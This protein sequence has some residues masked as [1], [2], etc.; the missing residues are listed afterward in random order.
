M[1]RTLNRLLS[2]VV[3][4]SLAFPASTMDGV[5]SA[6]AQANPLT[7]SQGGVLYRTRIQARYPSAWK[8]LDQT[9]IVVLEKGVDSALILVT[10]S[11]LKI[12]AQYQYWPQATVELSD[13]VQSNSAQRPD[14]KA[15]L[16]PILDRA[17]QLRSMSA[18]G[19]SSESELNQLING[20]SP[21]DRQRLSLLSASDTDNDGLT[22]TEEA[23]WC[24]DPNNPDSDGDTVSDGLEVTHLLAGNRTN[25]KPF[26][27]WPSSHPGCSDDDFDSLPDAAETHVTGTNSNRESTDL[28]KYD[29][30]QEF[31][32]I[33]YCPG[34]P[35]S[36]GYGALPRTED[37][38]LGSNMPS[39]VRAPGNSPWIAAFPDPTVAINDGT[40]NVQSV[41]IITTDHTIGQGES[42][43]Y[44]TATTVGTSTSN[45]DITSWND[46]QEVK[47]ENSTSHTPTLNPTFNMRSQSPQDALSWIQVGG[48]TLSVIGAAGAVVCTLS[49]VCGVVFGTIGVV[50]AVVALGATV[51]EKRE[52]LG[53][54]DSQHPSMDSINKPELCSVAGPGNKTCIP[55]AVYDQQLQN[56]I[57]LISKFD[58]RQDKLPTEGGTEFTLNPDGTGS[59]QHADSGNVP[60]IPE[61]IA[62]R[63]PVTHAK[64]FGGSKGTITTKYTETTTTSIQ[65][66]SSSESWSNATATDTAHAADLRFTYTIRNDGRDILREVDGLLFN[67][68]LGGKPDPIYTYNVVAQ[69]GIIRNIQ[70]GQELTLASNPVPLTLQQMAEIDK[71]SSILITVESLSYGGDQLFFQDAANGG[72][73]VAIDDGFADGDN[74]LDL[75]VL[76][77]YGSPCGSDPNETVQTILQR[78]F[79][80][81]EDPEGTLLSIST[82]EVSGN[83][84]TWIQHALTYTSWWNVYVG[85][86]MAYTGSLATTLP[87]A[88]GALVLR[89]LDDSDRD[90]YNDHTEDLLGTDKNDPGSHPAPELIAGRVSERAGDSVK[91]TVAFLNAGLYDAAGVEVVAFAPDDTI[92]IADNSIG[93]S[94][95]IGAGKRVVLGGRVFPPEL[96]SGW[97]GTANPASY[98]LY[99]GSLEKTYTLT[100][101]S[102]GAIGSGNLLFNWTDGTNNG[103]LQF[104]ST[105]LS[106][107]PVAVGS[108]GLTVSFNSGSIT[109]GDSFTIRVRPAGDTIT[110]TINREPYTEPVLVVSYNDPQGKHRLISPIQLNRLDED[111]TQ[112][113]GKMIPDLGLTITTQAAP[114]QAGGSTVYYVVN[115]PSDQT[116]QDAHLFV[117]YINPDG[118]PVAEQVIMQTLPPGPSVI[119]VEALAAANAGSSPGAPQA[120]TSN[121][122][123]IWTDSQGNKLDTSIRKAQDFQIDPLPKAAATTSGW[124]LGSVYQGAS[125]YR[126]FAYANVGQGFLPV[127]GEASGFQ[128]NLV[129]DRQ[130]KL[131]PLQAGTLGLLVDTSTPGPIS[132][133]LIL[134]T[135]DIQTPVIHIPVSGL[136]LATPNLS[137]SDGDVIFNR[138]NPTAGQTVTVTAD[139]HNPGPDAVA[140]VVVRFYQ[141]DPL[142]AGIQI[143]ADQ[144]I[145]VPAGGITSPTASFAY[146]PG[147]NLIHVTVD[148]GNAIAETDEND[149][150]ARGFL[151]IGASMPVNGI[152]A[153]GQV[154]KITDPAQLTNP[155]VQVTGGASLIF[156]GVT[157]TLTSL[158]VDDNANVIFDGATI[159]SGRLGHISLEPSNFLIFR[160]GSTL[161]I[162]DQNI[163]KAQRLVVSDSSIK[164]KGIDGTYGGGTGQISSIDIFAENILLNHA[165]ISSIGGNGGGGANS[166]DPVSAGGMGGSSTLSF[167]VNSKAILTDSTIEVVGGDGGE[168]GRGHDTGGMYGGPGSTG[169][170]EINSSDLFLLRSTIYAEGGNGGNGGGSDYRGGRD[171]NSGS[172]AILNISVVGIEAIQSFIKSVGGKGGQGGL[173]G[174][175]DFVSGS[176]GSGGATELTILASEIK[177]I[178]SNLENTGG[179]GGDGAG[180]GNNCEYSGNGGSG[181][182][183]L[184]SIEAN[185]MDWSPFNVTCYAGDGGITPNAYNVPGNGGS[186]GAASV[187]LTGGRVIAN[188]INLSI[189]GGIGKNGGN[190]AHSAYSSD[191]KQGGNGGSG[192]ST[193]LTIDVAAIVGETTSIALLSGNGGNGGDG[194]DNY[195]SHYAGNGGNG[196]NLTKNGQ[197]D[198]MWETQ[199]VTWNLMVGQGGAPGPNGIVPAKPGVKGTETRTLSDGYESASLPRHQI[200]AA[201]LSPGFANLHSVSSLSSNWDG[202]TS[203]TLIGPNFPVQ[204]PATQ[205]YHTLN[206]TYTFTDGTSAES[207]HR[208]YVYNA[209]TDFDSDGLL[210]T[211]E[212]NR[213]GTN[214]VV[215]DTDGDGLSDGA[216]IDAHIDPLNPDS[217][218]NGILDGLDPAVLNRPDLVPL[219]GSL[220]FSNDTPADGTTVTLSVQITNPGDRDADGIVVG[221]YDGDPYQDGVYI[222]GA[223]ISALAKNT[224]APATCDW[225]TAGLSGSHTLFAMADPPNR[226]AEKN[227]N[228]NLIS[229]PL[230]VLTK[231]DLQIQAL[232]PAVNEIQAGQPLQFDAHLLNTGQTS[233]SNVKVNLYL[234]TD[235]TGVPIA[236]ATTSLPAGGETHVTLPWSAVGSGLISFTAL[237]DANQTVPEIDETNNAATSQVFVGWGSPVYV[238]AGSANDLP[239]SGSSGYG[240]LTPGTTVT[241]CGSQP[242]QTYRQRNSG[243]QLQYRY[244]N[245]LASHFYHLDLSFYLCSGTRNLRILVDGVEVANPVTASSTSTNV[246]LLLD[247]SL[248]TDHSIVVTIERV[249][250]LGGPV[251]SEM[252]LTDIR[253]CYLDSGA[254]GEAAYAGAAD[255]CGWQSGTPDLSWGSLPY[256]SVRYNDLASVRYRFDRLTGNQDYRLNLTFFDGDSSSRVESVVIDGTPVLT[257]IVPT[258]TPQKLMVDIPPG[259]YAADGSILVDITEPYQ[260]I[261]SE[262]GLEEKTAGPGGSGLG[263]VPMAANDSYQGFSG[264]PLVVSAPG[265]LGN[266]SDPGGRT[267]TASLVDD[268]T[269]GSLSLSSSG[270]FTYTSAP[271][272]L[273]N[274]TFTYRVFNGIDYST[275]ATVT[276]TI[277][278]RVFLPNIQR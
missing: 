237:V 72:L 88:G 158:Q 190:T 91:I 3:L 224:T 248:Y 278:G 30:G 263:G 54:V 13:L 152:L 85:S 67:L 45:V 155:V 168:G 231:P 250:G 121:I 22:N 96:G 5:K 134:R 205:G 76:P 111:L 59:R 41:A 179:T 148:P 113:R 244:D 53:L 243:E 60:T 200:L 74:N 114:A 138:P 62:N 21:T 26:S 195:T 80:T 90:G 87:T 261:I 184:L 35:G 149:N 212:V 130:A 2:L 61:S 107:L 163:I 110:Y 133:E 167:N 268:V 209:V 4:F 93:G 142:A 112:Y 140:G 238:D 145:S 185:I 170:L 73:I 141:G 198:L 183:S 36:C 86:T 241:S 82:P 104:G 208:L 271:G 46:W 214:P 276:I 94:G 39:F 259:A 127:K 108:D 154:V 137:I 12:L 56:L 266:D 28:D 225:N 219:A 207:H 132:G 48:L 120:T 57:D 173:A 257:N 188:Q 164:S 50:G 75:Y 193:S 150:E 265:V 33:T 19:P 7:T 222:C 44:S 147:K 252:R 254:P 174:S 210:D 17:A 118:T 160:N 143:G 194:Y 251:V 101:V 38:Y 247:P 203:Q 199:P 169:T 52:E 89:I 192:G 124:D 64:E 260:P 47:D 220:S 157:A 236:T 31:F 227:K 162:A 218:F 58:T 24:T 256:Q 77:C 32:G 172:N 1:C 211:A 186:G 229:K 235:T 177:Y 264:I 119:P 83:Q 65:E 23:W 240:F 6:F 34:G 269:H 221:F 29:D 103:Q 166:P 70:P 233:A 40:L 116:I 201:S 37:L 105:Y 151:N 122:L 27:G 234:G 189:K 246:S 176:G 175:T 178:E 262:I 95:R 102:S 43:G 8:R 181:G 270:G 66:F 11:Q 131:F 136:V 99:T 267:L 144:I 9:G 71:G 249:S 63:G 51:Y 126:E 109:A 161:L 159:T 106:P 226:M 79:P 135:G 165:L 117:E 191:A 196:G 230:T 98:G 78:G 115:N 202:G 274:D 232:T 223:F 215:A 187:S 171:G 92:T 123:A 258:S 42:H 128:A 100:A 277:K 139:I 153:N 20:I 216:E 272:Y 25:G 273:G 217:N 239:Y 242:Y 146:Q 228:N 213:Y 197:T 15:S 69:T 81:T 49:V 97:T 18:S 84:V 10:E 68:Y 156:Q 55:K 275:P 255:G 129:G 182:N 180:C 253:Y 125:L 14:L 245:L 16:K 204:V 206:L